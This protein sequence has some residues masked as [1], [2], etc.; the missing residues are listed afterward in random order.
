MER[1]ERGFLRHFFLG[2]FSKTCDSIRFQ[3]V[4]GPLFPLRIS[5]VLSKFQFDS[6][7]LISASQSLYW[8]Y[9]ISPSLST[10]ILPKLVI[11]KGYEVRARR[12]RRSPI[13]EGEVGLVSLV[14]AR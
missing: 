6:E 13:L 14:H 3:F 5:R 2:F 7:V 4:G 9:L 1:M 11:T 12:R 10:R 8:R